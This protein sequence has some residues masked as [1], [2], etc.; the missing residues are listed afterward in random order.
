MTRPAAAKRM[1]EQAIESGTTGSYVTFAKIAGR[2]DEHIRNI[3]TVMYSGG[4]LSIVGWERVYVRWIPI[5]GK[6]RPTPDVPKPLPNI[7]GRE[8][9]I[10][11]IPAKPPKKPHH[12][13]P[14]PA[15]I[16]RAEVSEWLASLGQV[17]K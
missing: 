17:S 10:P 4:S 13:Q 8:V 15:A 5:Y 11:I 14:V 3:L 16:R 6:L 9:R 2:K 12:V 1:I 7:R